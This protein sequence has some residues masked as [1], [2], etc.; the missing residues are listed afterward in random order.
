MA[1]GQTVDLNDLPLELR[2]EQVA[3]PVKSDATVSGMATAW[4]GT[5]GAVSHAHWTDALA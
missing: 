4:A 1:P 2:Q 3:A 5:P